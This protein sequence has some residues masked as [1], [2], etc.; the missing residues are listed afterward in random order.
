M[1]RRCIKI[2]N[3]FL[4]NTSGLG[5][6]TCRH[7]VQWWKWGW[8]R[9]YFV[10]CGL[11]ILVVGFI[12]KCWLQWRQKKFLFNRLTPVDALKLSWQ[13]L[14]VK[15]KQPIRIYTAVWTQH[16]KQRGEGE[17]SLSV[18]LSVIVA[19]LLFVSPVHTHTHTPA[20][21]VCVRCVTCVLCLQ[22]GRHGAAEEAG[23]WLRSRQRQRRQE[24]VCYWGVCVCLCICVSLH[25]C[26]CV[27]GGILYICTNMTV[28]CSN[29]GVIVMCVYVSMHKYALDMYLIHSSLL[30]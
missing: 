24:T 10:C 1:P 13:Q 16:E 20:S 8:W 18:S 6:G 21:C 12:F 23:Q 11:C 3:K 4:K 17:H 2:L 14:K 30:L 9:L 28:T 27:W 25:L 26:V 5:E 19:P 22:C 15:S 7:T 29:I